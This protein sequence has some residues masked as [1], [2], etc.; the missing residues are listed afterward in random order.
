MVIG[1]P[2][3]DSDS[4]NYLINE[5]KPLYLPS[6]SD[7][8]LS[9][10]F[11]FVV[12][13][14]ISGLSAVFFLKDLKTSL[15]T[16]ESQLEALASFLPWVFVFLSVFFLI[17]SLSLM[18][19]QGTPG[20]LVFSLRVRSMDRRHLT[21]LQAWL[22]VC[23]PWVSMLFAGLPFLQLFSHHQ[24]KTFYD[25]IS[26]T[27][28]VSFK[29]T[30]LRPIHD[31]EVR[32]L[33]Q[34]T[35]MFF[36]F[37]YLTSFYTVFDL[38]KKTSNEIS[39]INS[40]LKNCNASLAFT[41]KE[42][43]QVSSMDRLLSLYLVD[44]K[45]QACLQRKLEQE[46]VFKEDPSIAYLSAYLLTDDESLQKLYQQKVC[47]STQGQSGL[48]QILSGKKLSLQ[49][50]LPLSVKIL[51][52]QSQLK[53]KTKSP[54]VF[55]VLDQLTAEPYFFNHFVKEYVQ[56]YVAEDGKQDRSPASTEVNPFKER[57]LERMGI[58]K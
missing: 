46:Q 23:G 7:R 31:F 58:K 56:A 33:N 20:Q 17:Q 37:I 2:Y 43:L 9:F 57:F 25:R 36:I 15:L 11:D 13:S 32:F 35:S 5:T 27:E 18:W 52:L 54:E 1:N 51:W 29:K 8:F 22:R 44:K 24:R 10:A 14:P 41:G 3:Q 39:S 47:E 50:K 16:S 55:A 30:Y 42:D 6:A 38:Q 21:F 40:E 49:E 45:Y 28:V 34:W 26:D 4:S 48:C 19:F 53:E 12:L